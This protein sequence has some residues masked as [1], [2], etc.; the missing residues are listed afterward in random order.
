MVVVVALAV[1]IVAAPLRAGRTQIAEA[2]ESAE[3]AD[4]EAAKEGKLREI[5]DAELDHRLGKLSREDWQNLDGEL[6]GEAI[7]LM[8]E[9]DEL[10]PPA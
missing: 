6:R 2:S 9:L 8:R 1:A 10:G 3:R 4:L 5:R 7:Q